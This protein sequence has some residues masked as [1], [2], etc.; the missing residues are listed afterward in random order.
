MKGQDLFEKSKKLYV[1]YDN[2]EGLTS[3]APVTISGKN[4]GKVNAIT[5]QNNGKL[6]VELLINEDTFPISKS[7]IAQIYEPGFIGGSKLR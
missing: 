7:S 3:S 5:L 1:E 4:I 6:L 2:V